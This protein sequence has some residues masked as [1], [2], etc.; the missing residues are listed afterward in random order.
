MHVII[1]IRLSKLYFMDLTIKS[2]Q[3][4]QSLAIAEHIIFQKNENNLF[5][6]SQHD[7]YKALTE[8]SKTTRKPMFPIDNTPQEISYLVVN[9][10]QEIT[11]PE[12]SSPAIS[13]PIIAF[14]DPTKISN[15]KI[16]V[17]IMTTLLRDDALKNQ[18]ENERDEIQQNVQDYI[19]ENSWSIDPN[20]WRLTSS[21]PKVN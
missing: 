11:L 17:P 6:T 13:V 15:D 2:S 3:R 21:F 4:L 18:L 8:V 5:Y 10:T 19:D 7:F 9:P 1:L 16:D 14:L 12:H 20:N